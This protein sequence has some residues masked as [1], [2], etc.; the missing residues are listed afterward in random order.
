MKKL[1]LGSLLLLLGATAIAVN[2]TGAISS[3][4]TWYSSDNPHIITGN[5]TVNNLVTLTIQAGCIVKFNGNFN[6]QVNGALH[7]DGI[8]GNPVI[9]TSNLANPSKGDWQYIYFSNAD[10]GSYLNYCEIAYGG[11]NANHGA[12]R[13]SSPVGTVSLSYCLIEKSENYGITESAY[14]SSID[15]CTIEYCNKDGIHL[16]NNAGSTISYCNINYNLGYGINSVESDG[17][18]HISYCTISNNSNYAINTWGEQVK[19]ITGNMFITGNTPNAIFVRSDYMNS[20]TWIDHNV[21]YVIGGNLYVND[22]QT[23]TITSGND[24]KFNG[25]Y[26]LE[27]RGVLIANGN[28]ARRITFTSN[29]T[30][31]GKGDW[32]NIYFNTADTG[33]ILNYCNITYGGSAAGAASVYAFRSEDNV[34]ITNSKVLYSADHGIAVNSDSTV[35]KID[36]CWSKFNDVD[37]IFIGNTCSAEITS[38]T[39]SNSGRYGINCNSG[40]AIARVTG[41]TITDN[42]NYAIRTFSDNVKYLTKPLVISGNNPDAIWVGNNDITTGTWN[43]FNVPY[44]IAQ[45]GISVLNGQTW[46]IEEG[47]QIKMNGNFSL[48]I[49]GT[50]IADGTAE[51]QIIFT[52]N[53]ASPAPGNWTYLYFNGADAG[54]FM[55]NCQVL[56]GGGTNGNIYISNSAANVSLSFCLVSGSSN[57]GIYINNSSP[58]FINCTVIDNNTYGIRLAGASVPTFG[59]DETEWNAIYS[60]GNAYEFRNS[61]SPVT[62]EYIFW[63]NTNC[64]TDVDNL[65]Y[66]DDES[67][68]LG[69]VDY[70]PVIGNGGI[71]FPVETVWTGINSSDWELNNNWSNC[72]PCA[73]IDAIIPFGTPDNPVL[74]TTGDTKNLTVEPGGQL[75]VLPSNS[76]TVHGDLILEADD[77]RSASVIDNAGITVIGETKAEFFINQNRWHFISSPVSNAISYSFFQLYLKEWREYN[78]TWFY[79]EPTN[80]PLGVGKGWSAWS[81]TGDPGTKTV[82]IKGG[83]LNSGNISLP[84]TATDMN[85][86]SSIGDG[87]GWNLVGNPYASAIDWDLAGWTKTNIDGTVYVWDGVQYLTWNGSVGALADGVIPAMQGFMVKANNFNP[88]LEVSNAARIHG[89]YPY[90]SE[91][92]VQN[93]IAITA[94]GNG[95]TDHAFIHFTE[96]ATIGFDHH[97]DAYKLTGISAAPQLYSIVPDTMLAVNTLPISAGA[98]SVELGFEAGNTGDYTLTFSQLESFVNTGGIY[99]ED[100]LTGEIIQVVNG[101]AY[102][103]TAEPG[104]PNNRFIL[105]FGPLGTEDKISAISNS[106]Y[107]YGDCIY[108]NTASSD[109]EIQ[110]QIVNMQGQSVFSGSILPG[111]VTRIPVDGK[112]IYIAR[113]TAD[114][115]ILKRKMFVR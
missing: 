97:A 55:D 3:D 81:N 99:L 74:A 78:N 24:L 76:L 34:M 59:S 12:V 60:N 20:G 104:Q 29:R 11:S 69:M 45:N 108:I 80:V 46:T 21:P 48:T 25:N 13:I 112:G 109:H 2:H 89:A 40:T 70:N 72:K 8:S 86:S 9:F 14:G 26:R 7:A 39:V 16:L 92:P 83:I 58:S 65:I 94:N 30:N 91:T 96:N 103:F 49:E 98:Q 75:T 23:L 17:T 113:L 51:N 35:L 5:V 44:V 93:L 6:L 27:V 68:T 28:S 106:V 38:C 1:L 54:C 19:Y 95:N 53:N 105:H 90:K 4:Q 111:C 88:Y 100:R 52:S 63:G 107:S 33:C 71:N 64:I 114:G 85:N 37:G 102:S 87:E 73:E 10:A 115:E 62:A 67:A 110:V 42:M 82:T 61:T 57:A 22:G 31:P 15:H 41:S 77:N 79:I 43:N 50:M 32:R 84:V 47:T 66:D 36:N 101:S 56:Y 18:P